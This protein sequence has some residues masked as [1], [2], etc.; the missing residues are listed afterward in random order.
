MTGPTGKDDHPLHWTAAAGRLLYFESSSARPRPVNGITLELATRANADVWVRPDMTKATPILLL[1]AAL[2][3]CDQRPTTRVAAEDFRKEL[4]TNDDIKTTFNKVAHWKGTRIKCCG[5]GVRDIQ[6]TNGVTATFN[7]VAPLGVNPPIDVYYEA[8]FQDSQLEK[9]KL[10]QQNP[11][12]WIEGTI[13]DVGLSWPDNDP[14]T[15]VVWV[16][17]KDCQ[18]VPR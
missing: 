9:V 3:G 12:S 8:T 1:A 14:R 10:A 15:R 2:V 4:N 13:E 6:A 17:M 16:Q 18:F 5:A 7:S 11:G